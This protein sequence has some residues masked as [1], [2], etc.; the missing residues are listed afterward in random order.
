MTCPKQASEQP[1][2]HHESRPRTNVR[3]CTKMAARRSNRRRRRRPS[4][5]SLSLIFIFFS[6][7]VPA[8]SDS[9]SSLSVCVQRQ[10]PGGTPPLRLEGTS[11]SSCLFS[12][13]TCTAPAPDVLAGGF[14]SSALRFLVGGAS[15]RTITATAAWD[16]GRGRVWGIGGNGHAPPSCDNKLINRASLLS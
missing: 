16:G 8:A 5:R 12:S 2:N 10:P 13:I 7:L 3:P 11:C 9:A 4:Y 14:N 15:L 1:I 6:G